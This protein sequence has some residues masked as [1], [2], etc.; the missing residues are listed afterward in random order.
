MYRFSSIVLITVL[1]ILLAILVNASNIP[2]MVYKG[3]YTR[4]PFKTS[5]NY[6]VLYVELEPLL[7]HNYDYIMVIMDA[8]ETSPKGVYA[9]GFYIQKDPDKKDLE[10]YCIVGSQNSWYY[11]ADSSLNNSLVLSMLVDRNM[12]IVECRFNHKFMNIS[13][14]VIKNYDGLTVIVDS[15]SREHKP[16]IMIRRLLVVETLNSSIAYNVF[17]NISLI[18]EHINE[19]TILVN[20]T[21]LE[22]I[23]KT[24][25]T[26]QTTGFTIIIN[27]TKQP[28]L[29]EYLIVTAI[30]VTIA[31]AIVLTI[32]LTHKKQKTRSLGP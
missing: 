11:I 9:Y 22:T 29:E 14:N 32:I 10:V 24:E 16:L 25:T 5:T 18:K 13:K 19:T 27:A 30:A 15:I 8:Q 31:V 21:S 3:F 6:T 2:Y 26:P 7:I 1:F 23:P 17:N 20:E 12:S 28:T 4:Y